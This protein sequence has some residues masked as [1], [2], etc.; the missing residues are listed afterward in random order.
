MKKIMVFLA[1][2]FLL[3]SSVTAIISNVYP[4]SVSSGKHEV[5]LVTLWNH[6]RYNVDGGQVTMYIPYLDVYSKSR[7]LEINSGDY[8][9]SYLDVYVP[10]ARKGYYP[11][12]LT[13]VDKDGV[14]DREHTWIWVN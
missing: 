11:V 4:R 5:L 3:I 13:L 2:S 7:G 9:R 10:S 12:I 14:R 8:G 6:E 1:I